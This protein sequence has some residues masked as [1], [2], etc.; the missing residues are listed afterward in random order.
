MPTGGD[1][2]CLGIPTRGGF[3]AFD[4]LVVLPGVVVAPGVTAAVSALVGFSRS[5]FGVA[6]YLSVTRGAIAGRAVAG[7]AGGRSSSILRN[8]SR[9]SSGIIRLAPTRLRK[10]NDQVRRSSFSPILRAR[11][12]GY[13]PRLK[14]KSTSCFMT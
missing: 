7:S 10:A 12:I 14:L 5:V 6:A 13:L 8:F 4:G 9:S 2:F 11:R 1:D 3:I